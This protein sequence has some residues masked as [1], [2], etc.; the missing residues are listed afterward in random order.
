MW[1]IKFLMYEFFHRES[2]QGF[3]NNRF[4]DENKV[5]IDGK[6]I[7][8]VVMKNGDIFYV[9]ENLGSVTSVYDEYEFD[10]IRKDDIVIDI[11]AIFR[12]L[13]N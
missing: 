5:I 2:F 11:G 7:K 13:K 3:I 12:S 8:Q 6:Y 9:S 1:D 4:R 10:D